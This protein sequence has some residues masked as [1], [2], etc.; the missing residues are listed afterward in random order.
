MQ[1][2]GYDKAF[3]FLW[4]YIFAFCYV[5]FYQ[6]ICI[7]SILDAGKYWLVANKNGYKNSGI[8]PYNLKVTASDGTNEAS[9]PITIMMKTEDNGKTV[10]VYNYA[11]SNGLYPIMPLGNVNIK[12]LND[13]DL[14][15][16][17]FSLESTE[18]IFV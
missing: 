6:N 7:N 17:S 8:S 15:S 12:N 11:R 2:C 16:K 9:Y 4:F 5:F 14:R 1:R 10:T 13:Q 18:S 3:A